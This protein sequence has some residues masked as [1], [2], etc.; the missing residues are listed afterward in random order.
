[1]ETHVFKTLL[2]LLHA[3]YG[4]GNLASHQCLLDTYFIIEILSF[5]FQQ[6]L[7]N[8]QSY[9]PRDVY[10]L[11]PSF[12]VVISY[13]IRSIQGCLRVEFVLICS[14]PSNTICTLTATLREK[15]V[16]GKQ[17]RKEHDLTNCDK[18]FFRANLF[19]PGHHNFLS[20]YFALLPV[21][22]WSTWSWNTLK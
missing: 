21:N 4:F 14:E 8:W 19:P 11:I 18:L 22:R 5:V 16:P 10:G 7:F 17:L 3:C 9:S 13:K 2:I 12:S 1:M 6:T 15:R 20:T